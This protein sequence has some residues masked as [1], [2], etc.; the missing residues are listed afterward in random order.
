MKKSILAGFGLLVSVYSAGAAQAVETTLTGFTLNANGTSLI[1]FDPT[2]P[3]ATTSIAVSGDASRIDHI[4]FRPA[5]GELYGF[6]SANDEYFIINPRTGVAT[7]VDDGDVVGV[8]Q[9]NNGDLDFNPTIDRARLVTAQDDNIVFNPNNGATVRVTDLF[10]VEGDA[11]E[12]ANP[13]IIGNAYT[14]NFDGATETTQFVLDAGTDSL[15]ILANNAGTITSVADLT[16]D[17]NRVFFGLNGGFDILTLQVET[18]AQLNG[19]LDPNDGIDNIAYALLFQ[20]GLTSLFLVDLSSG[21]L[22]LIGSFN[23]DLGNLR[24][25]AIA[26][27]PVPLPAAAPIFLLGAAGFGFAARGRKKARG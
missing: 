3:S 16:L 19:S 14:N 5:T 25:L 22:D 8:Q 23:A 12:G 27:L 9:S 17:G 24:G 15:G 1:V 13:A 20:G 21:A 18:E 4:D 7:R 11:N 6:D 2:D 26:N 10:Y